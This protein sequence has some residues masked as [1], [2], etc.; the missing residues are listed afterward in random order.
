MRN[1]HGTASKLAQPIPNAALPL[2]G[3]D[4][5]PYSDPNADTIYKRFA[6]SNTDR[7][8]HAC[9]DCRNR[10][11][12]LR[13]DTPRYTKLV[14]AGRRRPTDSAGSSRVGERFT[15]LYRGDDGVVGASVLVLEPPDVA[16][17]E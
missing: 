10:T 4:R 16:D 9:S 6:C 13:G 3:A 14:L 7:P 11:Q 12:R 8:T 2:P 1:H 17:L 15:R 5:L